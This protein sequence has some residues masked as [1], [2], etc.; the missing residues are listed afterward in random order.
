MKRGHGDHKQRLRLLSVMEEHGG[1]FK[2]V[3]G[4]WALVFA[5]TLHFELA[6]NSM[7]KTTKD[8]RPKT[9][10]QSPK[11]KDE[12]QSFLCKSN[13]RKH[14]MWNLSKDNSRCFGN[15]S[16]GT[17]TLAT[18]SRCG[19]PALRICLC[20]SRVMHSSMKCVR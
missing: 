9:K 17:P 16:L 1:N 20:L 15:R 6:L 2:L 8:Q 12:K 5:S 7:R 13:S 3:L 10:D 18:M 19:A 4:L 14:W 11:S